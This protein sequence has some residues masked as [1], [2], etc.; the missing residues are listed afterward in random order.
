VTITGSD[1]VANL[2]FSLPGTSGTL[3]VVGHNAA[4]GDGPPSTLVIYND[5]TPVVTLS[6]SPE[7]CQSMPEFQFSGGTPP[8]GEYTFD[9]TI[10]ETFNAGIDSLGPHIIIYTFTSPGGCAN[11]DT[12]AVEVKDCPEID[13]F[14]PTA[15]T[16]DGDGLNDL[17]RPAGTTFLNFSLSIFDRYG[18]MIFTTEDPTSG[19]DGKVNGSLCPAGVYPWV[20]V[21]EVPEQNHAKRKAHGT[22]M[23]LR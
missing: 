21:F 7:I 19:W 1:T 3:T 11:S 23:L 5:T 22:V 9:G 6:V 2:T 12:A 15:F 20:S 18:Q 10:S 14:F 4:C 17:F 8:G 13:V 16:P